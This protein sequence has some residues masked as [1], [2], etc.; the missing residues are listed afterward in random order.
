MKTIGQFSIK[1]IEYAAFMYLRALSF[2]NIIAILRAWFEKDVLSKKVLISHIEKLIDSLPINQDVTRKFKP[3]RYG[4]YALDGT[5][6]K[7]RGKDIVL[8]ILFDV[9]TLDVVAWTFSI[10]EN[11]AGY[12][13]LINIAKDEISAYAKG[14][15]CD[16]DPGLLKALKKNYPG[17]PIQ[18]CVFHKYSRVGQLI[19]FVHPKTEIDK[20]IKK[21]TE[22]VLFAP[23]KHEA[24]KALKVLI[25]YARTHQEH[26]GKI[27]KVIGVLKRNFDL[28]LTHYDHPVMS[29][30]NN[31]LEG[32]NHI[33]KRK[34]RL[35]KGFK[36]PI[37]ITR[38]LK[39]IILDYRFHKITSSKFKE[40][41][42][43]S[44]L[45]L[46]GCDLPK[47]HNWMSFVRRAF[48]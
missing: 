2:D 14:F 7:Y 47:Y 18:L 38:W 30:Y 27:N 36:K 35:M 19:P 6:L 15:F 48:H 32:F 16:G 11:E 39:L 4:Y 25:G 34:L 28:L 12:Q 22:T 24:I 42:G 10:Q 17:L 40:R 33:I 41:N 23:T 5:W 31:V 43:K 46:A 13:K 8:L 20:L 26:Q 45:Q 3:R 21:M 9:R 44:P 37:N 1:M 29:P